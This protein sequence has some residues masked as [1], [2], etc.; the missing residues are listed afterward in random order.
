MWIAVAVRTRR[1][2]MVGSNPH[3]VIFFQCFTHCHPAAEYDIIYAI[4][5]EKWGSSGCGESAPP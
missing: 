3:H 1:R 4:S 5:T 2:N